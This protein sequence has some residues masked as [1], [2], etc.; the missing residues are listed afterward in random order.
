M[1]S[2]C[3]IPEIID[4]QKLLKD[5]SKEIRHAEKFLVFLEPAKPE[6]ESQRKKKK[7]TDW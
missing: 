2:R 6:R 4:S 1:S 5:L 3:Q 7:N